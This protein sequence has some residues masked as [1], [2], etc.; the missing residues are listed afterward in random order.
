[1]PLS[2]ASFTKKLRS[3]AK[4][5]SRVVFTNHAKQRMKKRQIT[6][7]Q[8]LQSLKHGVIVEPAHITIQ[9]DWKATLK[10]QCAGD[11]VQVAVAIEK[12]A[13]GE[14]AVIVTVMK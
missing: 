3:I 6:F 11:T 12:Q 8:V 9:G 4:D 13:D 7:M 10:H 2:N 14:L 1:M 5:S